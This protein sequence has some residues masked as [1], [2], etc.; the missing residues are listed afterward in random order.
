[1][2]KKILLAG[3]EITNERDR[4]IANYHP[5]LAPISD[6]IA[7]VIKEKA[8]KVGTKV[9]AAQTKKANDLIKLLSNKDYVFV[10]EL[11]TDIWAGLTPDEQTALLDHQLCYCKAEEKDDGSIKYYLD[12]P[13]LG[14]FRDEV[15]RHG[16]W[17]T[18]KSKAT[19]HEINNVFGPKDGT[20][21]ILN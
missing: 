3:E 2:T 12:K 5:H 17:S 13:D 1:M 11:A 6:L 19:E 8:S 4:L 18:S 14:F 9:I 21:M 15:E 10:I 20:E 16:W 7:I